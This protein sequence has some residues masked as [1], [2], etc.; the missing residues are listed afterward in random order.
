MDLIQQ[1]PWVPQLASPGP[2]QR[3][4]CKTA[5]WQLS[6]ESSRGPVSFPSSSTALSTRQ[7]P[8]EFHQLSLPTPWQM[9]SFPPAS[10]SRFPSW[11]LPRLSAWPMTWSLS[12][13]NQFKQS[14]NLAKYP[15]ISGAAPSP[16]RSVSSVEELTLPSSSLSW[17]P[18]LSLSVC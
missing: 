14:S 8:V 16:R 13:V 4:F 15:T 10:A 7:F 12:T 18:F 6:S 11:G 3:H 1:V 5:S 2:S 17:G 9:I